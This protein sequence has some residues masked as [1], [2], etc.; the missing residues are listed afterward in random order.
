MELDWKNRELYKKA[1]EGLTLDQW[2]WEFLRRDPDYQ[3]AWKKKKGV[4]KTKDMNA[5]AF[6]LEIFI[7]P[8]IAAKQIKQNIKFIRRAGYQLHDVECA[9]LKYFHKEKAKRLDKDFFTSSVRPLLRD[10]GKAVFVFDVAKPIQE[11]ID[12]VKAELVKAQKAYEKYIA[13]RIA[14]NK[15]RPRRGVESEI[16]L[17]IKKQVMPKLDHLRALDAKSQ[18]AKFGDIGKTIYNV[19]DPSDARKRGKR[20]HFYATLMWQIL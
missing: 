10:K 20:E 8:Q 9:V 7:D 11:Q 4:G 3:A 14:K 13:S 19:A 2:R 12:H 5:A 16:P 15:K 6:D 1:T 17:I 18:G